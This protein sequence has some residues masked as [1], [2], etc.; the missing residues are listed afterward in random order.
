MGLPEFDPSAVARAH[1]RRWALMLHTCRSQHPS[2]PARLGGLRTFVATAANGE[3]A[4][5]AAIRATAS[6]PVY[7]PS[8]TFRPL[9]KSKNS[10]KPGAHSSGIPALRRPAK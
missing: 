2:G 10:R 9:G 5:S 3:V 8:W 4:P 1:E 6:E 7:Y